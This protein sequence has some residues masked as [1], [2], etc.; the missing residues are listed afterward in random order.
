M[1]RRIAF[2]VVSAIVLGIVIGSLVTS[3]VVSGDSIY[4]QVEKFS[5][6]LNMAAKNYVEEV[7]TQKLTKAAIKGM[8]AELDPHSVYI[9]PKEMK[10]VEEDFRG[11]FEGI[12]VE[13]DIINDTIT[14]VSRSLADPPK[15]WE[16]FRAIRSS[17]LMEKVPSG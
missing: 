2:Y 10:R 7:D 5:T 1:Q 3:R 15:S 12:G 9:P 16:F 13:F 17:R 14:I 11:S 6:I 4:D 8:L